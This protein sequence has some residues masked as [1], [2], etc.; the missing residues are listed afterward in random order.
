MTK[1]PWKYQK[2]AGHHHVLIGDEVL[3]VNGKS[4]AILISLV[5]ELLTIA[6]DHLTQCVYLSLKHRKILKK[7]K[8][9]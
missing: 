6:K 4:D 8:W 1:G 7:I 2:A 3:D 5:P 9:L